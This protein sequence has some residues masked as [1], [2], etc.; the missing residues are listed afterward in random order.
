VVTVG[1]TG[2]N[3]TIQ[4]DGSTSPSLQAVFGTNSFTGIVSG[5]HIDAIV[6]GTVQTTRGGCMYTSNGELAANLC[7]DTLSGDI[8]YTPQTNG[9]ADC[10]TMQVAGFSSRQ[11]FAFS[12]IR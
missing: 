6:T 9:Q 3:V 11:T 8:V 5:K 10:T 1:Q 2:T 7:G 4:I 12:R